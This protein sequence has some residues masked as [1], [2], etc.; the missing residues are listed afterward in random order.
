MIPFVAPPI[1]P[2]VR[3][4]RFAHTIVVNRQE[5]AEDPAF[6]G[7]VAKCQVGLLGVPDDT[8]VRMNHGRPG[9]A[10]GP[11][12]FR[13]ALATYGVA[14]PAGTD[15]LAPPYPRVFDA[16]DV[17]PGPTL[18]DTH[19]RVTK[20]TLALLQRGLFPV[21]VGGGHDLTFPFVRA[22]AQHHG[23]LDG[24]YFDAHLDVRPEQGSGMPFRALL[25]G[26]FARTLHVVG[27]NPLVNS[28]E[29]EQYFLSKGGQVTTYFAPPETLRAMPLSV[30]QSP[31]FC[32]LDMDVF[33]VAH[34]PGV[35]AI[36]PAGLS[37]LDVERLLATLTSSGRLR[38]F[39][40]MELNPTYDI[41]HR[42]ARLAA[43]MFLVALRSLRLGHT[44]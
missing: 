13:A 22:V 18:A 39:D 15:T 38:C 1:W 35:S 20:A 23:S 19:D 30:T 5:L 11:H 12:A 31:M 29:H 34:A 14:S 21:C 24:L 32:S 6:Q 9:A 2:E 4:G 10:A 17:L 43:H 42:T 41:D 26:G 37:P 3:P 16:G 44:P 40:I 28:R 8:G 7:E 36:N 33:N 25:E 27:L